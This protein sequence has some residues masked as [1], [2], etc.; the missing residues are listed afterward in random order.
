MCSKWSKDISVKFWGGHLLSQK[1][2]YTS[3]PFY[4]SLNSKKVCFKSD[5]IMVKFRVRVWVRAETG[6]KVR[7]RVM[8][9]VRAE[10]EVKVRVRVMIMV[11]G[12]GR[13]E[14]RGH[15]KENSKCL[16]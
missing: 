13:V 10:V 6:V 3:V 4:H 9:K 2:L 11:R 1:V 15:C 14:E 5:R 8:I 12:R 16:R 7:V